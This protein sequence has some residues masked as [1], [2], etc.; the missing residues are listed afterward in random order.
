MGKL[1]LVITVTF[2]HLATWGQKSEGLKQEKNLA[3]FG[4][5]IITSLPGHSTTE[6]SD[7][8]YDLLG[9]SGAGP[10]WPPFPRLWHEQYEIENISSNTYW[11]PSIKVLSGG[12]EIDFKYG[13]KTTLVLVTSLENATKE[14]KNGERVINA[15]A[16][17]MM[18]LHPRTKT[19][20][21]KMR[22]NIPM[23][24][25]CS[26]ELSFAMDEGRSLGVEALGFGTKITN[27]S[28]RGMSQT[29]YSK[30]FSV[31]G[32]ESIESLFIGYCKNTFEKKVK[33]A[34]ERNFVPMVVEQTLRHHPN[35]QCSLEAR[36]GKSGDFDCLEWF[37]GFDRIRQ[38]KNVPR[39]LTVKAGF[40]VCRLRA[41]KGK[42]CPL[43]IDKEFK[44]YDSVSKH[45]LQ[46]L[47]K[48]KFASQCDKGLK[49]TMDEQPTM[50][51]VLDRPMIVFKGSASC[52]DM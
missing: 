50:Y 32:S 31:T 43:Y 27:R 39:C 19:M 18:E 21:P 48:T 12:L 41:K 11:K 36:T 40:N 44:V 7:I 26:Y 10:G 38:H 34:V 5:G 49:C 9:A 30:F 52:K 28:I 42:S 24:A 29:V 4:S 16:F 15:E 17:Q 23:V 8:F 22:D 13:M 37:D 3:T 2:M 33:A 46:A 6:K 51:R 47:T 25:F 20:Y 45:G 35:N 1:A 14:D